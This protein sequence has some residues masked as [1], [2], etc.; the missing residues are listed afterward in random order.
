[1]LVVAAAVSCTGAAAPLA[2]IV[3]TIDTNT[4]VVDQLATRPELSSDA[5]VDSLHVEILDDNSNTSSSIDLPAPD[6]IEW[7]VSFGI[8][9]DRGAGQIVHVRVRAYNAAFVRASDPQTLSS[10]AGVIIDR[11]IDVT[12]S[13][14]V[15]SAFVV[16]SGDCFGAAATLA[17]TRLPAVTCIDATQPTALPSAGVT[18]GSQVPASTSAGTWPAAIAQPCAGSPPKGAACIQGGVTFLGSLSL[19]GIENALTLGDTTPLRPARLDPYF[20]DVTEFTVGSYRKL[21]LAGSVTASPNSPLAPS[22]GCTWLGSTDATNDMLPLNCVEPSTAAAACAA[23]G[24]AL[25]TEARWEH[26]ARGR[27]RG[28][29]YPWGNT[30]PMCCSAS[31][32]GNG[33]TTCPDE[34]L[35]PVGTHASSSTCAG[36]LDVSPDGIEDLAGNVNEWM[37]DVYGS[38]A[39]PCWDTPIRT[40]PSCTTGSPQQVSR[41]GNLFDTEPYLLSAMR[42]LH[43][44]G[45]AGVS[46]GFRC[47][48]EAGP[49]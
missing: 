27:G 21:V 24:G 46:E 42:G 43:I 14:G 5:S 6:P 30:E 32:A 33:E 13:T 20:L 23:L 16:L 35:S 25:P 11:L 40:N 22:T 36:P 9:A 31:Y 38:Y 4:P 48:Y 49:P 10:S 39:G 41:G 34:G 47:A 7:P 18:V 3:V 37:S 19:S 28:F 29:S 1:M 26:A 12:A 15:V 17:T 45:T 2:Q 44:A 8:I